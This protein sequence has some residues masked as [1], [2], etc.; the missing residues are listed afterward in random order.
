[1]QT[2]G[3]RKQNVDFFSAQGYAENVG[4]LDT[5]QLIR[6]RIDRELQGVEI[7]LDVGNGG[8]F[9]YDTSLV[10][11][12]EGVDLFLPSSPVPGNV[13]MRV[14]DALSLPFDEPRFD[15][16]LMVMLLHHLAGA[17]VAESTDNLC[18]ALAEARRVALPGAKV[19]IVESCVPAWFFSLEKLAFPVSSRIVPALLSHPPVLQY[20]S[21]VLSRTLR[22]AGL[23]D[24]RWEEIPLGRYVLQFGVKWPSLLTPIKPMIFIASTPT[25]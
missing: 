22:E 16:V 17:T 8:V 3:R 5:Y 14:G 12:I 9:D 25:N 19:I 11:K 15:A 13:T 6:E 21:D 2:S 23:R 24:V 20:T 7:L 1:M 18:K 10:P 4:R